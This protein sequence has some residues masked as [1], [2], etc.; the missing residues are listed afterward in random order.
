MSRMKR[1][2]INNWVAN[3]RNIPHLVTYTW[4]LRLTGL[5]IGFNFFLLLYPHDGISI[6][7][8]MGLLSFTIGGFMHSV[9]E[10][11]G[12]RDIGMVAC[13]TIGWIVFTVLFYCFSRGKELLIA[14]A[15][16]LIMYIICIMLTKDR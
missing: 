7:S 16:E 5:F 4:L 9:S 3:K 11:K 13:M 1:D 10:D 14:T 15:V 12:Y 2:N 8:V 6:L